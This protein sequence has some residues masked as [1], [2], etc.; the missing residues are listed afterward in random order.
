[1]IEVLCPVCE[2]P[3]ETGAQV[4][5]CPAG[6]SYDVARQGYVNLLTVSQKHSLHP[7]DTR[8]QL[9]ARKA[10]LDAGYYEPIADTVCGLLAPVRPVS[11][12]DAGCGEGYY[13]SKLGERLPQAER[14]GLDI[15]KDAVR[16]AAV[17]ERHARWLAG[18]VSHLPFPDGSFGA[19]ICM[20]SMT[21]AEEFRRVLLPGGV[22]LQV[23]AG[24][25]HLTRLKRLI[26][27]ELLR[28]EKN[29][30]PELP[31]FSLER[32]QTL[33]FPFRLTESRQIGNLL[34]MTPHYWRVSAAGAARAAAAEELEDSA[35]VIFNYYRALD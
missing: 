27:P 33:E 9:A 18:T 35:Q 26:Y 13:L 24:G 2:R 21:A 16:F 12:L 15:S 32:T 4:W 8:E 7:G 10:F 20:F 5:T 22:F 30:H 31:G 25:E 17:R 11:V 29:L 3:L 19:V 23:L 14:W 6:H 1:M 34:K 28:R